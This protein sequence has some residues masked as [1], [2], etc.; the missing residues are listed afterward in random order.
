MLLFKNEDN[1]RQILQKAEDYLKE[2]KIYE[3]KT[4][5]FRL[6]EHIFLLGRL[7]YLLRANETPDKDMLKR[8]EEVIIQRANHKPL[9]YIIGKTEFM[10]YEFMVNENVLIPRYDTEVLVDTVVKAIGDNKTIKLLDMCTGSSCI[11]SSIVLK[12]GIK[13]AVAVDISDK[14]LEIAKTNIE[15]LGITD[16]ELIQSDLFEKVDKAFD[17]I[18]SN[19][20]YIKTKEI[21]ELEK[22][23]RLHEPMLALDGMEDGLYFYRKITKEAIKHLL[24]GGRIFY[25]IGCDQ[26][27]DVTRLLEENGFVDIKVVKDLAGLNRVVYG[28]LMEE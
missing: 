9:Q 6:F 19:P 16:I 25:E 10:G 21:E 5:S 2:N 26:A 27:E 7:E 13:N 8:Y 24:S 18:V 3:A 1:Y 14:A 22:E 11:V 12:T 4:D 20:P 28:R 15:N 23:V 17:I